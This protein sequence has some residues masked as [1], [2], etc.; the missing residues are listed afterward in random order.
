MTRRQDLVGQSVKRVEDLALLTGQGSYI[1]DIRLEGQLWARI[2]RSTVAHGRLVSVDLAAARELPGVV[3]AFA[4][5]DI[6]SIETLRIPCRMSA[7]PG[8]EPALQPPLAIDRVRYVG[9]PVAVVVAEDPY[10]AEDGAEEVLVEV[11]ELPPAVD[12]LAAAGADSVVLHEA[13]GGNVLDTRVIRSGAAVEALFDRAD[14]IVAET[15]SMQRHSSVPMETRGLLA[16]VEGSGRLIVYGPTK[17]KHFNRGVL[18]DL[19]GLSLDQVRFVEPDVGGGFGARGEFYPE[20]FLIPWLAR[21][22]RRPV[23]WIEDRVENLVAMNHSRECEFRVEVAATEKGEL[24]ALRSE[25]FFSMGAYVRTTGVGVPEISQRNIAGPYHWEGVEATAHSVMTNK[26][27]LG[28]FR[29][30][31]ES[32][33]TYA[34]ERVLDILS[35]RLAMDPAELRM[36]NLVR[37]DQLPYVVVSGDDPIIYENGNFPDQLKELTAHVRYG[38]LRESQAARRRAGEAVGLGFACYMNEAAYGPFEWARVVAEADGSFTG[39]VG[40]ASV[41]QGLRTALSQVLADALEIPIDQVKI[42]HHDTDKVLEGMGAYADRGTAMGGSALMLAAAELKKDATRRGA[43]ALEVDEEEVSLSGATVLVRDRVLGFGE[44]GCSG[45]ARFERPGME[46]AFSA[47]MALVRVEIAT[48][49][50]HVELFAGAHDTGR[51]VNPMIVA[52]QL[53]GATA[54]GVAGSLFEEFSYDEAGQPQSTSF[55]DYLI[56][57]CA[58]MPDRI[59]WITSESPAPGN[60]VG[61]KGVGCVGT[62]GAYGVIANAVSDALMPY[63]VSIKDL[64]LR[65]SRIRAALRQAGRETTS[66]AGVSR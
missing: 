65:P 18:A 3:A 38:E 21:E 50:V 51:V 45:E 63:G 9:E 11:E 4:A 60:L 5:S 20:D 66:T 24:L 10:L 43:A 41:G 1:A 58:E 55:M 8:G 29:G 64:P 7:P 46:W 33:A 59:S 36:K 26:T 16:A 54:H 40:V 34:R 12:L 57:T 56:P 62:V 52:G 39:Y 25:S 44:L 61:A 48:G 22:L 47:A 14:V 13:L 30:P 19:L 23:K 49:Q 42:S 27:P 6:P 53:A 32:E 15:V 17:V 37:P 28:T 2:V 31:G 35:E